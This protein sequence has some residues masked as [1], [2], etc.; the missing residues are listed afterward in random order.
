VLG[1]QATSPAPAPAAAANSTRSDD[2]E[3]LQVAPNVYMLVAAGVNVT[4]Q[5]GPDGVFIVDAAPA[6]VSD[7]LLRAIRRLSDQPIRF[8][9][10]TH[11]HD[12]AIGGTDAIVKAGGPRKPAGGY[13]PFPSTVASGTDV[14]AHENVNI[15]L[16]KP[17]S[18]AEDLP[19]S[20]YASQRK[21]MYFNGEPIEMLAAP[22]AHTDGDTIV[23][24]RKS[25]VVSAGGLLDTFRYPVIDRAAGGTLKG[26]IQGLTHIIEITVPERNA[27]GGTRVIPGRGFLCNEID[28]VEYRNMLVIIR[29]RIADLAKTGA[30]LEQVKAARVTLDY[31]GIYGATAGPWTTDVFIEAVYRELTPA[32]NTR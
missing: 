26:I 4:V 29:D 13:G 8:L 11:F 30:T 20:T 14:I 15:R 17:G 18:N 16:D 22:A 2:I 23:Y 5:T 12:E 6:S 10:T 27:M 3:T 31:D 7:S 21:D 25:D 28:V 19:T 9:V 24:F 32:P 1:T